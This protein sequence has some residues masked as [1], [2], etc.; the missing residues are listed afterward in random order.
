[1]PEI[2]IRQFNED[3]APNFHALR[4]RALREHP[5]AFSST[6]ERES[7]YA[8]EFVAERLRQAAASPD[9]FTLGAYMDDKLVGMVGFVRM[10]RKNERHRGQLWGMYIA[11]EHQGKGIGRSLLADVIARAGT[12]SGLN[13]IELEVAT[14]ND[15]ARRLYASA[16]FESCGVNPRSRI[17]DGEYIDDERMVLFLDGR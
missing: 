12:L 17:L 4:L 15:A 8:M 1:M 6:H 13:Q 16:G 11:S 5:E 7:A 3:D 14:R 9:N 10:T 2:T